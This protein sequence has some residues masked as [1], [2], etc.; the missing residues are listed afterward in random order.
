MKSRAYGEAGGA[1]GVMDVTSCTATTSSLSD[2]PQNARKAP[3]P[4]SHFNTSAIY[5][6]H[7]ALE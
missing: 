1:V 2:T 4:H 5:L 3:H 6:L 7:Y